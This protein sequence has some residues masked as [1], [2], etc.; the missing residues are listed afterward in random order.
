MEKLILIG[1]WE[2]ESFEIDGAGSAARPWGRNARGLLIYAPSGHMSVSINKDPAGHSPQD[3]I[4]F[5]AG[6]FETKGDT[7]YHQVT[8]ASNPARVGRDMIR[9]AKVDGDRLTLTTPQE[10][11]GKAKLVWRRLK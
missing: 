3:S 1:S 5:Y 2:L 9:F 10:S 6:T 7:V 8:V 11:Y 4:L